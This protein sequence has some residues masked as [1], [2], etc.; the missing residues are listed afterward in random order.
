MTSREIADLLKKEDKLELN[1]AIFLLL[2]EKHLSY[3]EVSKA[4]TAF[5]Q[6][7]IERN[8]DIVT[9]LAYSLTMYKTPKT[10]EADHEALRMKS[11][12]AIIASGVFKG[13]P[14]EQEM[15]MNREEHYWPEEKQRGRQRR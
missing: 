6:S 3:V 7:E 11:N 10:N 14:F 4:Y 13:T 1:H 15:L 5:L 12:R 2:K 9:E 8:S